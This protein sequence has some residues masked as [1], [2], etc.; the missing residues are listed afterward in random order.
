MFLRQILLAFGCLVTNHTH[1]YEDIDSCIAFATTHMITSKS[2]HIGI[3]HRFICYLVKKGA[4]F[5]T[6]RPVDRI[7]SR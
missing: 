5:I 2:K 3:K 7:S 1:T 6:W 4:I